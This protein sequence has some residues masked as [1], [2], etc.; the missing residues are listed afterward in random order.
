M[1]LDPKYYDLLQEVEK[2]HKENEN[3]SRNSRVLF[4]D[5]LNTFI[6]SWSVV[7][8]MNTHGDHVGGV[9]GFLR[10]VGYAV[11]EINPTRVIVVF[12]GRDG[13]KR[14][15]KI[16]SEYKAQRAKNKLRVNRGIYDQ[17]EEDKSYHSD[18]F[19][20]PILHPGIVIPPHDDM[21]YY[22]QPDRHTTHE[23][24]T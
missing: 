12:D 1:R 2:E 4:V 9:T 13:A 8:T 23:I 20:I 10:S 11:R 24:D 18:P 15:R 14:R 16:Y 21:E 5:G 3:R 19:E 17:D 7:P 6:R 22:H